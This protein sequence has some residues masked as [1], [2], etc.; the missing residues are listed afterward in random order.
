MSLNYGRDRG[1]REFDAALVDETKLSEL[2]SDITQR[3]SMAFRGSPPQPLRLAHQLGI[4]LCPAFA[5]FISP[6]RNR[7]LGATNGGVQGPAA[8]IRLARW[9]TS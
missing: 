7:N 3:A 1:R 2:G 6:G 8:E 9:L 4:N 5:A